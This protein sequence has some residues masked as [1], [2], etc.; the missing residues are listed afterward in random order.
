M[1]R[2]SC[3]AAGL[4]LASAPTMATTVFSSDFESG[5]PAEITGLGASVESVQGYAGL[6]A[7]GNQFAGSFLRNLTNDTVTLTLT[8]LPAHDTVDVLFLFAAIDSW[9]GSSGGF[10]S[11]DF[12]TVTVDGV[13]IFRESFENSDAGFTQT[14]VAPAGGE[15]ARKQNLGFS[16][17]SYHADSAYDLSI[18][19]R[20]Q[21]IA[22]TAS[23]LTITFNGGGSGWQAGAD[24]SWA[25]DNL[26]I[27]TS[28][29]EPGAAA[30]SMLA[31]GVLHAAARRR[32]RA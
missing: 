23:T 28:V 12:F 7:A 26:R 32:R 11:G 24:E 16:V 17:G 20:F 31:A 1:L 21:G 4:L 8:G 9:D 6:G 3:L 29:P 5:L 19:S 18:D 13:T 2:S 14:Y 25:I 10:P 15:L 30:L 22:H 27:V